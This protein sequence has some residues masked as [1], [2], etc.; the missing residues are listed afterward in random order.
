[1]SGRRFCCL[2]HGWNVSQTNMGDKNGATWSIYLMCFFFV[3]FF[4]FF[5]EV[6][7]IFL[8]WFFGFV[9]FTLTF[10]VLNNLITLFQI[11]GP[12]KKAIHPRFGWVPHQEIRD[13]WGMTG[14]HLSHLIEN[15]PRN[16]V[17][18]VFFSRNPGF[19]YD[20]SVIKHVF[21]CAILQSTKPNF[22]ENKRD[23]ILSPEKCWLVF[24]WKLEMNRTFLF[25]HHFLGVKS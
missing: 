23:N 9:C 21:C 19:D 5:V 1:M 12:P 11:F 6:F 4:V 8:W 24:F 22:P 18:C 2:A 17:I 7:A 3:F 16:W 13:P 14:R 10:V 15:W 25:N 20:L